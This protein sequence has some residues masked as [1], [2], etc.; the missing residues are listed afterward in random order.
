MGPL[1]KCVC[2]IHLQSPMAWDQESIV[3]RTVTSGLTRFGN[4]NVQNQAEGVDQWHSQEAYSRM[5]NCGNLCHWIS[6]AWAIACTHSHFLCRRLQ[7]THSQGCRPHDKCWTSKSRDKQ[8][9]PRDGCQMHDT[10]SMWS[11]VSK[12]PMHGRRQMQKTISTQVPIRNGDRCK[13]ISYLSTQ[14]YGVHT[15]GS[16]L[17]IGQSLGGTAQCVFVD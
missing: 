5:H 11:Y 10:W 14:R 7:A 13:R 1:P 6:K 15:F 8:V 2:Y 4:P 16:W 17:W 3:A 12:R 9:G